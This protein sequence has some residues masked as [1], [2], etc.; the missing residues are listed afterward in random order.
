MKLALIPAALAAS[1]A[2]AAPLAMVSAPILLAGCAT[3]QTPSQVTAQVLTDINLEAS[4][5]ANALP[6]MTTLPAATKTQAAALIAKV[7]AAAA[8]MS[9]AVS[10]AAAQATVTQIETDVNALVGLLAGMPLPPQ[11]SGVLQAAVVLLPI[12]EA[13]VGMAVP[14]G[15]APGAM[16][17]AQ[18]RLTLAAH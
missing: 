10:K 9:A 8:T 4:G 7:Q 14:V 15:A 1:L 3:G 16:S 2:Y 17:P 13:G 18:A 6:L 11:V 5:L 12:I